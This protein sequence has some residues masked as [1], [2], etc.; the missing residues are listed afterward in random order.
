MPRAAAPPVD[1]LQ[2]AV[3]HTSLI[4][5]QMS[6]VRCRTSLRAASRG[7][8][9]RPPHRHYFTANSVAYMNSLNA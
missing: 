8:V 3:R 9:S 2:S 6:H 4:A 7:V 5:R 1:A